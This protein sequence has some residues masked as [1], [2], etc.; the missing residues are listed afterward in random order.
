MR[1]HEFDRYPRYK[2]RP[3]KD[4]N[5]FLEGPRGANNKDDEEDEAFGTS[6]KGKHQKRKKGVDDNDEDWTGEDEDLSTLTAKP[7]STKRPIY[8]T[9]SKDPKKPR[10][11]IQISNKP[12]KKAFNGQPEKLDSE[13]DETLGGFIVDDD[14][15]EEEVFEEETE[16][17]EEEGGDEE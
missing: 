9:R 16:E 1:G 6:L 7:G 17:E 13:D 8:S 4:W 3:F 10:A 14:D 11:N 2:I 15:I 12:A 5:W